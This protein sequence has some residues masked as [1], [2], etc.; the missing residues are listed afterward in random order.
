MRNSHKRAA[1]WDG[2]YGGPAL[3]PGELS[4]QLTE[5]L[6]G[7]LLSTNFGVSLWN[8]HKRA[9][10]PQLSVPATVL[11]LPLVGT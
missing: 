10:Q 9:A 8:S 4:A 2:P 5:R 1:L 3:L 6:I 11:R 7:N